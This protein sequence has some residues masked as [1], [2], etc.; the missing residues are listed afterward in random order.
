MTV[1]QKLFWFFVASFVIVMIFP[2]PDVNTKTQ[3]PVKYG[4]EE[5]CKIANGMFVIGHMTGRS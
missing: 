4:K 5:Q 1:F 2:S 3:E